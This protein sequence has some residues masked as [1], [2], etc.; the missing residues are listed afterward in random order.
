MYL[1]EFLLLCGEGEIKDDKERGRE[2]KIV[3]S[4]ICLILFNYFG[5]PVK[6]WKGVNELEMEK[7]GGGGGCMLLV[8]CLVASWISKDISDSISSSNKQKRP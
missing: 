5:I 8:Q 3:K 4:T 1:K 2:S 6:G 7:Q